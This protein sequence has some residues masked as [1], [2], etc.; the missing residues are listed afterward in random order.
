MEDREANGYSQG[1]R[2]RPPASL[3]GGLQAQ[4][5]EEPKAS[6]LTLRLSLSERVESC[7]L[8]GGPSPPRTARPSASVWKGKFSGSRCDHILLAGFL[9]NSFQSWAIRH[10]DNKPLNAGLG[11]VQRSVDPWVCQAR[12]RQGRNVYSLSQSRVISNIHLDTR[13]TLMLNRWESG[14][15]TWSSHLGGERGF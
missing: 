4:A 2:S 15:G 7:D 9:L 1:R 6:C 5:G 8:W 14:P 12:W 10:L 3:P 13:Q 11:A